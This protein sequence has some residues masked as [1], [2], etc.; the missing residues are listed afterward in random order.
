MI[1]GSGGR[2]PRK[3]NEEQLR[4]YG[5]LV[6]NLHTRDTG[7]IAYCP[8]VFNLAVWGNLQQN[9][10]DTMLELPITRISINIHDFF[11]PTTQIITFCSR[12]THL[13]VST[14][15]WYPKDVLPHFRVLSHLAMFKNLSHYI[16][17]T[18]L[19]VTRGSGP[20]AIILISRSLEERGN[21]LYEGERGSNDDPR[22]V[23]LVF[24]R[25]YLDDWEEGAWGGVDMWAMADEILEKRGITEESGKAGAFQS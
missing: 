22:L 19:E 7:L 9:D 23:R 14:L 10:I 3:L 6:R 18:C 8:N 21:P 2:W 25:S 20:E 12:I 17:E 1:V 16:V 5:R 13:D 24:Q 15:E 4:K 11:S